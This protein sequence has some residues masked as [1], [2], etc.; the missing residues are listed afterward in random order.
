[1][2]LANYNYLWFSR[3]WILRLWVLLDVMASHSRRLNIPRTRKE[4][5][6]TVGMSALE[7]SLFLP[8]VAFPSSPLWRKWN[9]PKWVIPA[10]VI[11]TNIPVKTATQLE[12]NTGKCTVG[13]IGLYP[14]PKWT[15]VSGNTKS[16]KPRSEFTERHTSLP[17]NKTRPRRPVTSHVT[18]QYN[19]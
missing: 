4:V 8:T 5:R 17:L 11:I 10:T 19:L 12:G 6:W 14:W 18:L 9:I 15:G 16:L 3:L 7:A 13:I 2:Q 1:M